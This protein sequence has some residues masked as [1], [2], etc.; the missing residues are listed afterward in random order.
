[1]EQSNSKMWYWVG[2]IVVVLLVLYFAFGTGGRP[3]FAGQ[4][5]KIGVIVPLSGDAAAYGEELQRVFSYRL[6]QIN[7]AAGPNDPKFELVFEDG[8]CTGNDAVSAFQK[9]ANIDGVKIIIGGVCSSET[10]GIA[11][12]AEEN[13]VLVVSGWSSNPTI[14]D[15][16]EYVFSLSYSD[17]KVG[18]DLAKEMSVYQRVAVLTEQN[19]YNVGIR[20]TFLSAIQNYPSVTVV[21]NE[22]FP[23][24]NSDFRSLLEKI[25]GTNPQAILLNPNVGVTAENLLRQL[26]EMTSWSGYK[27]YSQYSYLS[28]P[29]R[30]IV[31]DF[32][33]GMI[34]IDAPNINAEEFLR[35]KNEIVSQKGTLDNLGNYY[36]ASALDAIN[37]LTSLIKEKGYDAEAVRDALAGGSFEGYIGT[38]EFKGNNFVRLTVG[39]KYKVEG[40]KAVFVEEN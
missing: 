8:K 30:A 36:T 16:N 11:P 13:E 22:T 4:T 39:G 33:E 12:L 21:S 17:S 7:A 23:K 40:G 15:Q 6:P 24:G 14:E 3:D 25:K 10:L 18:Q 31:G 35:V 38:I 27:L 29:T 19:D 26:T 34:I 37:L 5:V 1:M 9:L 20:D 2:G 32:T 28:D